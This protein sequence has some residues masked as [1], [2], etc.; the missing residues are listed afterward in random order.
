MA[1]NQKTGWIIQI[2]I[3]EKSRDYYMQACNDFIPVYTNRKYEV[4]TNIG[5]AMRK[6]KG[7]QVI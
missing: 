4:I 3:M 2:R 1:G 6:G 5:D 7:I